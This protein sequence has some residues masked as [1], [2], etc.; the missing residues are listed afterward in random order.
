MKV[1]I[2]RNRALS[3]IEVVA[4]IASLSL[5]LVL[6][7]PALAHDQ[8]R[9]SRIACA[10]NLRQIGMGFQIWGN[11][12]NDTLPQEVALANGG[13]MQHSLAPNVWFHFA[14]ISNEVFSPRIY[15]CPSDSGEP[16]L[17]FSG[18]PGS[19]YLNP[20]FANRAT[21]YFLGYTASSLLN[22]PDA[23]IAGDRNVSTA[24]LQQ[25]GGCSRFNSALSIPT[26]PRAGIAEWTTGL[27]GAAGNVLSYDGKVQQLDS[28]G[29]R[30]ALD[31]PQTDNAT[32]HIITPR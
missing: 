11:E 7:I 19:G 14:W 1:R 27:H 12:H 5:T 17:A 26:P 8:A 18:S 4:I 28:G 21:S 10:N 6:V 23:V 16:A 32:R 29:L 3:H 25:F 22:S 30:R 31:L 20:N 2:S 13:T 24:G 15:F 9:S